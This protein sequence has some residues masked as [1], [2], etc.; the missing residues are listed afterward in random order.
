MRNQPLHPRASWR[1]CAALLLGALF[2]GILAGCGDTVQRTPDGKIKVIATTM[3]IADFLANVGGDKLTITTIMK[4]GVNHHTYD[5]TASDVRVISEAQMIFMV[6]VGLEV[7]QADR[8]QWLTGCAGVTSEGI[9]LLDLQH[10]DHVHSD[11]DPHVWHNTMNAKQMVTNI[12][13]GLATFDPLNKAFYET[14]A[15]NYSGQIDALTKEIQAMID[16]IPPARRK[17]VTS[18][19]AFGYFAG[20]LG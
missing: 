12:T 16:T 8:D 3:Q 15:Q 7:A 11:G 10:T 18:H 17:L 5:P 1:I 20:S 2:V 19:E 13:A 6:G 4:E 14:N 9:S